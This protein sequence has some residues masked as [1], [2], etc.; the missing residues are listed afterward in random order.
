M[1]LKLQ[2]VKGY[3]VMSG[4]V[5]FSRISVFVIDD[6]QFM[7]T[8][9]TQT[10][11]AIGVKQVT[12]ARSVDDAVSLLHKHG[13][14]PD[15][16]LVDLEMPEKTGFDFIRLLQ[17]GETFA[18]RTSKVIIL[19]GRSDSE[20]VMTAKSLGISAYLLKPVSKK[21]LENRLES[22]LTH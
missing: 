5:D 6:E 8:L 11:N 16:F 15:V 9:L 13:L 14:R 12:A 20:G 22:V 19:T 2:T 18:S 21:N 1:H 3:A 10:L 17:A 4:K 7:T